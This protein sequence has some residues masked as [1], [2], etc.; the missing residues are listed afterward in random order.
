MLDQ[1]GRLGQHNGRDHRCLWPPRADDRWNFSARPSFGC[2]FKKATQI[3]VLEKAGGGLTT[4]IHDLNDNDGLPVK[5]V[6]T[7][8]QTHDI[9]AATELL[10]D[11]R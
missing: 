4:K 2:Y 8:G 3:A 6:V 7:L 1:G 9:Q 11:I 10:E 5:F